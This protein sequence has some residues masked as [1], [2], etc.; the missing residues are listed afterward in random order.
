[1]TYITR[2]ALW[3]RIN[4]R[5]ASNNQR[6][7]Y[8]DGWYHIV[9]ID[10]RGGEYAT[11]RTIPPDD[12]AL[13]VFAQE[14]GIHNVRVIPRRTC[15]NCEVLPATTFKPE[16]RLSLCKECSRELQAAEAAEAAEA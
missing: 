5:L 12:C 15:E 9:E 13:V 2:H 14:L 3:H 4:R 7:H 16:W 6:L 8:S 11:G 1:M 10:D